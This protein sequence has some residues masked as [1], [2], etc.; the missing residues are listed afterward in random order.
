MLVGAFD[1]GGS[2][3]RRVAGADLNGDGFGDVAV[4]HD[5]PATVSV[6]R[7]VPAVVFGADELHLATTDIGT[8]SQ[9]VTASIGNDGEPPLH[10]G[11]LTTAADSDRGDDYVLGSDACSGRTLASGQACTVTVR[12]RPSRGGDID[13]VLIVPSDAP[14]SADYLPLS[15]AGHLAAPAGAA[16]APAAGPSRP[17]TATSGLTVTAARIQHALTRRAIAVTAACSAACKVTLRATI[18]LVGAARVFRLGPV[19]ARL[20][21]NKRAT[22][23]LRLGARLR[24]AIRR[25]LSAHHRVTAQVLVSTKSSA[26]TV[27]VA[28]AIRLVA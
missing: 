6:F 27:R 21:A 4:S 23:R 22:M 12:F 11:Q 28:R 16:S 20:K 2:G 15:G 10:L 18:R 14:T 19:A 1:S 5:G 9:P 8:A 24:S 25:T 17:T 26:Q 3:A 7:N 13:G